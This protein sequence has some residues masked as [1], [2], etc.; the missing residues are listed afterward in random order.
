VRK[1]QSGNCR[2]TSVADSSITQ[3]GGD[4]LSK[5][6]SLG[7]NLFRCATVANRGNKVSIHEAID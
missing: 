2:G 7:I 6:V 5:S 4:G 1:E 3:I